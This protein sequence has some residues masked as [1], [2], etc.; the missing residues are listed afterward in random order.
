MKFGQI[1]TIALGVFFGMTLY[2]IFIAAVKVALFGGS[3]LFFLRT[4]Q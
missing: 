1:L 4:V 2:W 3:M